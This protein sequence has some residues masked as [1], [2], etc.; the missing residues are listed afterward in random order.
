M[1]AWRR[2]LNGAAEALLSLKLNMP[3]SRLSDRSRIVFICKLCRARMKRTVLLFA[4]MRIEC[5]TA[6]T[7]PRARTPGR[8]ALSLMPVA[9]K[10]MFCP[11]ARSSAA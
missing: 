9:Q 1:T 10:I 6:V 3:C 7:P 5:V 11:F 8:S 2:R 4:R